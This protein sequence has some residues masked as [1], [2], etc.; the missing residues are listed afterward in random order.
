LIE[1]VWGLIKDGQ[2]GRRFLLRGLE[3]VRA[4]WSLLVTAFNLKTLWRL[5]RHRPDAVVGAWAAAN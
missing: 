3:N 1:P 4:E 5:W 2:A